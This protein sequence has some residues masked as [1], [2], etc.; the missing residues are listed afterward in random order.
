MRHALQLLSA[1]LAPR[2][3]CDFRKS[4]FPP[5]SSD[6]DLEALDGPTSNGHNPRALTWVMFVIRLSPGRA[7][8]RSTSVTPPNSHKMVSHACNDYVGPKLLLKDSVGG[9]SLSRQTRPV[10][11]GCG[12]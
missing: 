4:H 9:I 8:P 6:R 3:F 1:Y 2:E 10:S 12:D 5:R 7:N 11:R